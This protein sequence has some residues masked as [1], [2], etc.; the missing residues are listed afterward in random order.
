VRELVRLGVR[1]SRAGTSFAL[2]QEGGHSRRRI[3]HAADMTGREIRFWGASCA[4]LVSGT[5]RA[6]SA[7]FNCM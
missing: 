1:F 2:G 4:R 5:V 6:I 3:L 7:S